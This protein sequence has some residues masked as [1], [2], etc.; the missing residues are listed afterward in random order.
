M[1]SAPAHIAAINVASFGAGLAAPDLIL[2]SAIWTLS[3]S[4]ADKVV[5]AAS[6]ITG[7][8][9]AHD[10][11]L[12]S[13]NTAETGLK[14]CDTCTGSAFRVLVRLLCGNSNHPSSE[15][16]FLI[17][18]PHNHQFLRWIEAKASCQGPEIV[19]TT[20]DVAIPATRRCE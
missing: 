15:G 5:W 8:S 13:S 1:L 12:S 4:S 7:T 16:T 14:L 6:V 3:A 10:T 9:P 2:G 11:R 17:S 19:D 18:T 20:Y